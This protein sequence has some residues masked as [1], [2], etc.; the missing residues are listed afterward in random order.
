MATAT[1]T[2]V[3]PLPLSER[4]NDDLWRERQEWQEKQEQATQN[5]RECEQ[6]LDR[7]CEE[8]GAK[9]L[10]LS[11]GFVTKQESTTWV[12]DAQGIIRLGEYLIKRGIVQAEEWQERVRWL[13][14][15][16]G[17]WLRH[18]RS[19]GKEVEHLIDKARMGTTGSTSWDGPPLKKEESS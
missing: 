1:R 12:Y 2:K 17:T 10:P 6:E 4:T 16:N 18:F 5:R 8:A 9:R 3:T 7:R 13:P 14:K 15:V 11:E 19:Y